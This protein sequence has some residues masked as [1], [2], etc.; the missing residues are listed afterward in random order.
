MVV[1]QVHDFWFGC[2]CSESDAAKGGAATLDQRS[3]ATRRDNERALVTERVDDG[4]F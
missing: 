1:E 4:F 3:L 2:R